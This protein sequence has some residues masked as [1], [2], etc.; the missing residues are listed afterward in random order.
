[1]TTYLDG[2]PVDAKEITPE[3]HTFIGMFRPPIGQCSQLCRCGNHCE[4]TT[5]H[6]N[7][8]QLG[9]YDIPQYKTIEGN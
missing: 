9:H 6:Y 7:H 3:R 1:M 4:T 5:S 2:K 8:Y